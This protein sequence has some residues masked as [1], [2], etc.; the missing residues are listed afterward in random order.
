MGRSGI[1]ALAACAVA[2]FVTVEAPK[3]SAAALEMSG[4][5]RAEQMMMRAKRRQAE[6]RAEQEYAEAEARERAAQEAADRQAEAEAQAEA[7]A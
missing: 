1:V 5:S 2:A 6:R 4:Q 7:Q 3:A